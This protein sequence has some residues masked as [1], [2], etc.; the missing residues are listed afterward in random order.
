MM[1]RS[2]EIGKRALLAT[3]RGFDVTSNNIANVNTPGYARQALMLRPGES[4]PAGGFYIGMGVLSAGIRQFRDQ[5][6]ERD[7][8][9][10]TSTQS[11]YQQQT[12]TLQRIETA[13]GEPGEQTI[14]TALQQFFDAASQLASN[15]SRMADRQ[16]FV[17]RASELASTFNRTS[18]ALEN[19]RTSTFDRIMGDVTRVNQIL[20]SIARINQRINAT[21]DATGQPAASLVDQQSQMLQ[22]LSQY[23]DISITREPTGT[24]NVTSS[25]IM[26]VSL[27]SSLSLS[28]QKNINSSTGE[29]T[30]NYSVQKNDGTTV[31]T[32]QPSNGEL[33]SLT[34][35][36][37]IALNPLTASTQFSIARELDRLAATL[38]DR[39]NTLTT[40]GYGLNDTGAVP[41]GRALFV[42]S[43]GSTITAQTISVNPALLSDPAAVP[44]SSTPSTPGKSDII[45]AIAALASDAT[46]LDSMTPEG[47]YG[48]IASQLAQFG[49]SAND[50]LTAAKTVLQQITAERESLSGVNL[51]E[52]ATNLIT[53]QR[54]FE[55]AARVVSISSDMLST[56]VNLG[57]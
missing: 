22:E 41:P 44:T 31:G 40:S 47:F 20:D 43:S 26:L 5:L 39:I 9:A 52:E 27:N 25:G 48:S 50:R 18:T 56:L 13:L 1:I 51:D 14:Q 33:A 2:L 11:F 49:A 19:L 8:R 32:F 6:I 23:L 21:L 12:T 42:P 55:A 46:F 45:A 28:V 35:S 10:Y 7:Q 4:V 38:A 37:N 17:A 57:R 53:Y 36:Y 34:E 15:P 29:T 54:A 3:Q 24:V 30:L 16:L